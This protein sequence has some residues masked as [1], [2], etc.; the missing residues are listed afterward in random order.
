MNFIMIVRR[1]A[2]RNSM[3][4]RILLG[5]ML[6][7]I[8]NLFQVECGPEDIKMNMFNIYL[9]L[10]KCEIRN[11]YIW[12]PSKGVYSTVNI[13]RLLYNIWDPILDMR[14]LLR[15]H[16]T[17]HKIK[18]LKKYMNIPLK[19]ALF[20]KEPILLLYYLIPRI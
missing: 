9:K 8:L 17:L 1:N 11:W 3:A 16:F 5:F 7:Y 4:N 2:F 6:N 15:I 10:Q 20:K 18:T 19:K 13:L 14:N 12:I